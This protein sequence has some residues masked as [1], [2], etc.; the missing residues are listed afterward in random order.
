M[1]DAA[2]RTPDG[3]CRAQR[4][5]GSGDHWYGI[6]ALLEALGLDSY[7]GRRSCPPC[8]WREVLDRLVEFAREKGLCGEGITEHDLFDTKLMGCLTPR[9][10]Q[11]N[12]CFLAAVC[13]GSAARHRL[14]L[15][16]QP[17]DQLHPAGPHCQGPEMAGGH[18]LRPHGDHH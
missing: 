16:L 11:V 1:I 17:G 5:A 4:P 6:N 3:L 14:V 13:R 9:P 15:R 12:G 8:R 10:S 7:T 2:Y 18:R